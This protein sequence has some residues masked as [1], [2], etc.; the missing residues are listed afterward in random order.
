MGIP[1][2]VINSVQSCPEKTIEHLLSNIVVC[3]GSALFPGMEE[4]LQ[5]DIRALA[6]DI[7]KVSV[8]VAEK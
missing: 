4:R 1:E 8:K 3:G 2:A 5:K 6:P 7:Y